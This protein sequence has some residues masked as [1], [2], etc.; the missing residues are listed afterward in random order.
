MYVEQSPCFEADG[1]LPSQEMSWPLLKQ[2]II[3][4]KKSSPLAPTGTYHEPAES[5]APT[6]TEFL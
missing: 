1:R 4:F 3:A 6:H 5:S 2:E